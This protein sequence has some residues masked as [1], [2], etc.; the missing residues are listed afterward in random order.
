MKANLHLAAIA[1]AV[2]ILLTGCGAPP[3]PT[4]TPAPIVATAPPRVVTR[5]VTRQPSP[6]PTPTPSPTPA[7]DTNLYQGNWALDLSYQ[8]QG[9]AIF[10][11]VRFTGTVALTINLEGQA[12]GTV[13]FYPTVIQPPCVTAAL[14]PE[15]IRAV[16]T[17]ALR[18]DTKGAVVADL[19]LIP[20]DEKQVTSLQRSCANL[21]ETIILSEPLFWPIL[22]ATSGLQMT[23][24]I[25][26]YRAAA[27]YDLSGP[28]GGGLQGTLYA[29]VQFGR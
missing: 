23:L 25:A 9:G 1:G 2:L 5:I 16:V 15:P 20:N 8:W 26:P 12:L 29:Q 7:F 27:L 21:P 6:A 4:A 13:D 14:D 10:T 3:L 11:D 22:K 18:L 28:T 19:T 24:P 17:G